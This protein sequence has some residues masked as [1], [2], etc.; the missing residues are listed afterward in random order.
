MRRMLMSCRS[1]QLD[2][3]LYRNPSTGM[4]TATLT[5]PHS[6]SNRVLIGAYGTNDA[7]LAFNA[8]MRFKRQTLMR[9]EAT[10]HVRAHQL[11]RPV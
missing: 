8:Y 2:A 7:I 4:F 5:T 11:A 3:H 10:A 6:G 9:T 1:G